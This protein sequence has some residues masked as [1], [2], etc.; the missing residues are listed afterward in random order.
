MKTIIIASLIGLAAC[1]S[2]TPAK[3]TASTDPRAVVEGKARAADGVELA[4]DV[5]GKGDTALVFVHGWSC[6]RTFWKDQLDELAADYRVVALDLGGH[7]KSG[8]NRTAWTIASLGGDVQA[9]IESLG[10]QRAIVIGHSMGG[11]VAL[12]AAR[13]MP[14]RVIG[15]VGVDTLHDAEHKMPPDMTATILKGF[16]TDFAGSVRQAMAFMFR[17]GTNPALV[18]WVTSR[19]TAAKPAIGTPLMRELFT[20]D[21]APMLAAAKVPIRCVNAAPYGQAAQATNVAAN[22]KHADFDAVIMDDVGHFL[23][24]EKPA[25]FNTR[26]RAVL[27]TWK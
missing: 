26:L 2:A 19:M 8:D 10:L 7:G 27:A 13:R 9:V 24:L 14:G 23:Q 20:L 6:D 15:V 21:L 12:D 1:G 17:E 11:P 25:E 4:Y 3:P 16:E 5:R 22:R 18:E